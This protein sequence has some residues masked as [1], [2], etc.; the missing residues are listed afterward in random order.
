MTAEDWI[1]ALDHKGQH[2]DRPRGEGTAWFRVLSAEICS[3]LES[4]L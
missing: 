3:A 2:T 4:R 1:D